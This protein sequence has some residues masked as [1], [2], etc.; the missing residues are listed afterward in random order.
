[1]LI[2]FNVELRVQRD[3]FPTQ[4]LRELTQFRRSPH[5]IKFTEFNSLSLDIFIPCVHPRK[6]KI[7][8]NP[9]PTPFIH[10]KSWTMEIG[11]WKL[12]KRL[13]K[14]NI[15]TN[16]VNTFKAFSY[17]ELRHYQY[18]LRNRELPDRYRRIS[19]QQKTILIAKFTKFIWSEIICLQ[20]L[21]KRLSNIGEVRRKIALIICVS[22]RDFEAHF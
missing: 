17:F 6:Q 13:A 2:N 22:E 21:F 8:L 15:P 10:D 5:V 19:K 18:A 3:P 9:P 1:M 4:L 20:C 12:K 7:T 14:K 11:F 16:V